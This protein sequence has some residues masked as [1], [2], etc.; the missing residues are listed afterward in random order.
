MILTDATHTGA[1][2]V[3]QMPIDSALGLRSQPRQAHS[4]PDQQLPLMIRMVSLCAVGLLPRARRSRF[5]EWWRWCPDCSPRG[6][7]MT[8]TT[9][10]GVW[11]IDLP[12][13]CP[14]LQKAGYLF[15]HLIAPTD[16]LINALLEGSR[17]RSKSVQHL[18]QSSRLWS[19][20]SLPVGVLYLVGCVAHWVSASRRTRDSTDTATLSLAMCR[21]TYNHQICQ[22][23]SCAFFIIFDSRSHGDWLSTYS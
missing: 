19:L 12:A 16:L 17:D 13:T 15:P 22:H 4:R 8:A 6:R 11:R 2:V 14:C 5:G 10:T 20:R 21:C 18:P 3:A 7:E 9:M 23:R 1:A